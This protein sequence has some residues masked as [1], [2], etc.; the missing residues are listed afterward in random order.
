MATTYRITVLDL[1][2]FN[3]A[4]DEP[5][6]EPSEYAGK[7]YTGF[8]LIDDGGMF[9]GAYVGMVG[10]EEVIFYEVE[11]KSIEEET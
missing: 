10:N 5:P 9:S 2:A 1:T 8:T 4:M 3:E 11:L 6:T 7:T